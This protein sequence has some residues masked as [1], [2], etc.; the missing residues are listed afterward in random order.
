M[1]VQKI[2][3]IAMPALICWVND[4]GE[5]Y[6]REQFFPGLGDVAF[7]RTSRD[8]ARNPG[9]GALPTAQTDIGYSPL[10]RRNRSIPNFNDTRSVTYR[11][12]I[13]DAEDIETMFAKDD[14]Q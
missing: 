12:S 10:V 3:N 8:R 9:A 7:Y 14:R 5:V 4:D 11:A 13:K 6:K 2:N 1:Q